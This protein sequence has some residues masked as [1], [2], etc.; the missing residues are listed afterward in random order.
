MELNPSKTRK[1]GFQSPQGMHD[2]L[3]KE[4]KHFKKIYN[5]AENIA[6]FYG[7]K[8]IE[9]PIIEEAG[10]FEKGT[11]PSTDIVQKQMYT[12]RTKGGD[13]LTL[14]PEGTPSLVRAY[15]E[16]GMFNLPQPIKLWYSGPFFRY[17]R[18]QAGRLRQFHQ[19]GFEVFGES[20][21]VI[22]TQIIQIFYNI[23]K[24][25]RFKNLTVEVNSIG[26]SQC[27]PYYKKL[28]V[29]YLKSKTESLCHSCQKRIKE[30]PLR[31]LDCQ[32]EK[33]QRVKNQAPQIIDHLCQECHSHFKEV[34]EFLDELELPYFLNPYLVRGLDYYTKTVFEIFEKSEEGQK[35]GAIV[36]GGRYDTLVK[37][38]S[39]KDTPGV[40]GAAGLERIVNLM[41]AKAWTSSVEAKKQ[42]F[43][44][45]LGKLAKRK[46]L[47]LFEEFRQAKIPLAETF[48]RDSL[49]AQLRSADKIE[50]EYTLIIG[51][52][53]A[54]EGII[55]IR[56]MKTGKQE[57]V[58]LEKI[59]KEM[60]KRIKK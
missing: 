21:A 57:V 20:S 4:Q 56:N 7:F 46:S 41:K 23:L 58:K 30:N 38:L 9:T 3:P 44:A 49:K 1:R 54:L 22:D 15:I 14:R 8:L 10:L 34:L 35:Q 37:L 24:E 31:I 18:P 39:G 55:L 48:G 42:I 6:N 29:N 50:A 25:L 17:E 40:G 27:R 52:K 47:R 60:K 16:H 13:W 53:E 19:I 26:D 43:L 12:F 33:C 11:G 5:I 32:E 59:V 45:Q 36:A 2:I 51:Q 28:L